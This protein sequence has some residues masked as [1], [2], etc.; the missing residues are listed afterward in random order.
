M[1]GVEDADLKPYL[2]RI[3]FNSMTRIRTAVIKAWIS[4]LTKQSE[5]SARLGVNQGTVSRI[6]EDIKLLGWKDK[7]LDTLD[8]YHIKSGVQTQ[9]ME[10]SKDDKN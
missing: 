5:I 2:A 7:W 9:V 8:G 3:V 6:V 10:G 4:G 1:I